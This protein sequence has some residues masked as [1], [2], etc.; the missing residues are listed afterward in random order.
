MPNASLTCK[1][2][3]AINPAGEDRCTACGAPID[4]L[5]VPPVT[6]TTINTPP[7]KITPPVNV[8]RT[9]TTP[10]QISDALDAAPINDQ[11]KE[12]LKAAGLG[13]G[14]LGVGTFFARTGAEAAA[15]AFSSF[16][17]GYYSAATRSALIALAGGL[18]I[19][20]M[21]GL[22]VKRPI[23]ALISAPLGT[24]LGWVAGNL[25]QSSL[26]ALPLPALLALAGGAL[27]AIVGSRRNSS[28][29][30]AKWY[31]RLRPFL[32]MAGGFLFALF[33]YMLGGLIK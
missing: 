9:D 32:G 22:A 2:C 31:G 10:E 20:L 30:V 33:G 24:I 5:V 4:I 17:V 25:L 12:G 1:Y 29:V 16:I 11:L 3:G 18:V 8:Q 28:N 23:G 14:A 21:V 13:I 7:R 26:P 19:G 6:V 27:L 15:I